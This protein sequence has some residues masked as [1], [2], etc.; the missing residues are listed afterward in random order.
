MGSQLLWSATVG[1][2]AGVLA[3]SF[4][5]L[6]P[7]YALFLTVITGVLLAVLYLYDRP[8]VRIGIIVAIACLAFAGGIMRMNVAILPMDPGAHAHIG[9]RVTVTGYVFAEPDVR[10]KNTRISVRAHTLTSTAGSSTIHAGILA[11][12]PPHTHVAYGDEIVVSGT[13]REPESFDTTLGRVFNYP[14][15]LAVSGISYQ[16]TSAHIDTIGENSGNAAYALVIRIKEV[17][18]NGLH[19]A[20]AEPYAGLAGGITV[21]D[22]RSIGEDL[23]EDFQRASLIH[24]L[25]LS[26]YNI[27]IVINAAAS[28]FSW[29]PRVA[30]FGMSG[31]VV[32]FF[33]A[34]SGGASSAVRAGSMALIAVYARQNGRIYL[35]L[36]V[37]ALVAAAMALW[38]P[39]IVAFDPGFQLSALAT[40]GLVAFTPI[41]AA[42]MPWITEAWGLREICC[43]TIATQLTVLPLLLYQNGQLSLVA[44]PANILALAPVPFA[45]FASF[46]AALGGIFSD[47]L[48]VLIGLPAYVLLSYIIAV[49]RF[50]ASLPFASV[51]IQAFG[52]GW[53]V[54]AYAILFVIWKYTNKEKS[55]PS[56]A[57]L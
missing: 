46:V 29:M 11:V 26:G 17:Y 35:P 45:M 5:P 38:N 47:T 1:F 43:S 57:L 55:D 27:T 10:E 44:L 23:S 24:M 16:L 2:L 33:M 6:G 14:A 34:L 39:Y 40:I 4:V 3:R 19:R 54:G 31:L 56:A 41:F 48:A 7:T 37:I 52:F 53:L 22:K 15:Y 32:L 21:G 50:F 49:T 30:Q 12:L 8:H 18:L 28:I 36:R 51:S 42:R 13:L 25:V 20:L 9:E